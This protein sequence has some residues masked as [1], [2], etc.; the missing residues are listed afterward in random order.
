[1][2]KY[3]YVTINI[4]GFFIA[5]SKEHRKII[6]DYA[7]KGYQYVGYIPTQITSHGKI[8]EIDLIFEM[9]Q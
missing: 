1:M 4:N 9:N 8:A 3:E 2:K 7:A 6:D 5:G